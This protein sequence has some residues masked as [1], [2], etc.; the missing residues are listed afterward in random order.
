[1]EK[2]MKP[3]P[4]EPEAGVTGRRELFRG[5]HLIFSEIEY[6]DD[7]GRNRRWE[8]VDRTGEGGAV[9]I[10]AR[11]IPDDEIV[12][13]RQFRPPAGRP[14]I[15]FPAGLVEQGEPPE[16]TALRELYE[17]TGFSGRVCFI[18][19]PG[20]SS[21]GLTGEPVALVGVEISGNDY[22]KGLPVAHPDVG[23]SIEV[24]RV[25]V[26]ELAGFIAARQE[27]GDGVDS[28]LLTLIGWWRLFGGGAGRN[29]EEPCR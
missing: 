18:Q 28:K 19:K 8:S 24:L 5:R 10:L 21:P 26:A 17:E 15:E 20:F 13:V 3:A 11:I 7:S 29:R 27:A 2:K 16:V 9:Y 1:M 6:R 22:L 14:M 4:A 12:L 25:P 23:E